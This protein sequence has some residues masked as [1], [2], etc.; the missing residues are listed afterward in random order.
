MHR[1]L[2]NERYQPSDAEIIKKKARKMVGHYG[3][4]TCD[5]V[6]LEQELA[7]HV[8]QQMRQYRPG[9]GTRA[10]FVNRITKNKLLNIIERR[11]A[12]KRDGRRDVA[13]EKVVPDVLP[14]DGTTHGGGDLEIDVRAVL[15]RLPQELRQ[16]AILLQE[17]KGQ[18]IGRLLGLSRGQVRWRIQL[19]GQAL[20]AAGLAPNSQVEQPSDESFR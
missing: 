18:E 12:Q 8:V 6:D 14:G 7:L 19:I 15:E 13:I 2:W 16:V 5:V 20:S 4:R 17:H 3:Y 9:R 1:P 11:T 10:Q